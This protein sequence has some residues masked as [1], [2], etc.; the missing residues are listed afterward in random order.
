MHTYFSGPIIAIENTQ[1]LGKMPIERIPKT[2]R[3]NEA[4]YNLIGCVTYDGGMESVSVGH[5]RGISYRN[6][7]KWIV[8][9]DLKDKCEVVKPTFLVLP[10]VLLYIKTD[11]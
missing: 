7:G 11:I 3:E 1:T 6:R 5:Y 2:L 10:A 4:T 8:Y 9:D